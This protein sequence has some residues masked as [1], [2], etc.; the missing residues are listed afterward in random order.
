[1]LANAVSKGVVV[2]PAF[3]PSEPVSIGKIK[4]LAIAFIIGLILP[5]IF[6]YTRKLL[7]GKPET[8][9]EIESQLDPT[10]LGEISTSRSGNSLVVTP[11]S[12]SSTVELFKLV[13]TNLQFVLK[14]KDHKVVMV[15][16]SQSGEGKSFIS[17][18]TA[19]AMALQ[20][21]KVLLVGLDIRKPMLAAYLN[22][23]AD[24]S[25]LTNYLLRPEISFRDV[26]QHVKEVKGLDVVV[27]G[28]I[29]PNPAELLLEP[30]L[31]DFFEEARRDYDYV[32]VDSAPV[33]MVS[34]SLSVADFADT[35]IYVTRI[36]VTRFRDLNFI[37]SIYEEDRMPKM[38]VI[39]NGTT[40]TQGY[41]YGYG[42][43]EDHGKHAPSR[44]KGFFGKLKGLF[45][46]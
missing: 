45:A 41:G 9:A 27:A 5:V 4:L 42:S 40:A 6:L 3:V 20:G 38:N 22:L 15:T 33:G 8:R 31:K 44:K 32:I 11:N 28:I 7:R 18:N 10:V 24:H 1:M 46:K 2:D 39:V 36:G 21:K 34:D 13:R 23:P 37:N 35:T 43:V 30:R 17:I 25:G 29:P 14:G 19:A 16:S 12:T 26:V